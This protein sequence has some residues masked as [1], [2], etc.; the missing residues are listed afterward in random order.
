MSA[1]LSAIFGGGAQLFNTQGVILSG[2]KIYTYVAGTTTPAPT[3]T[4]STQLVPNA[5][6]IILDSGGRTTSEIWIQNGVNYKFVVTDANGNAVGPT[7][8]NIPGVNQSTTALSEWVGGPTP[9]YVSGTQFSVSGNY[10]T[11]YEPARRVQFQVT[12]G[13]Y[14]GSVSGATYDGISATTVTIVPDST[15]MD[16]TLSAV[17]YGFL[18]S[19]PSSIPVVSGITASYVQAQTGTA[20]TT[21]GTTSAY[22]LTPSPAVAGNVANQEWDVQFN[23]TCVANPTISVNGNTAMN[24]V[25]YSGGGYTNLT[26]GDVVSGWRAKCTV[27]AGGT[28]MLVRNVINN[29]LGAVTAASLALSTPLAVAQG[30]TGAISASAALNNLGIPSG[31]IFDYA[32][33]SAPSG[34]LLC[35]GTAYSRT[36]Y[37]SLFANIGT[38]WGAGD[39]STTFNV[40]DLRRRSTI[41]SGGTQVAGPS[42]AVGATGGAENQVLTT[43]N[44]PSHNHAVTVNDSGHSHS[45]NDPQHSHGIAFQGTLPFSGGGGFANTTPGG[46]PNISTASASTGISV[47]TATT[48]ITATTAL[49]GSATAVTT[50]PPAAVVT[51][52]IKI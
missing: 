29:V 8:D 23:S 24:L 4:D 30:G 46:S 13:T 31:I 49:V 48:G 41:G 22:T 6:P 28:Q 51:K 25:K 19:T 35:D 1:V 27:L 33:T 3:F 20:F 15:S 26:A 50:F 2:G 37:S 12:S 21:A 44:L 9:N 5:N 52:I 32:G 45:L 38:T 34:F 42:T 7:I 10:T 11:V 39:G 17:N 16:S 43:A 40:P 18:N 47:N 14:Y 36:T